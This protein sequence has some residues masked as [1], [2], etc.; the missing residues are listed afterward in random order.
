MS[1]ARRRHPTAPRDACELASRLESIAGQAAALTV[2][3]ET[4]A[5]LDQATLLAALDA[6]CDE[7]EGRP[8]EMMPVLERL[9]AALAAA[10]DRAL[11]DRDRAPTRHRQGTIRRRPDPPAVPRAMVPFLVRDRLR[12]S[13]ENCLYLLARARYRAL[14]GRDDRCDCAARIAAVF[15]FHRPD[16][17]LEL[18]DSAG[19]PL[20]R[21]RACGTSWREEDG[22]DHLHGWSPVSS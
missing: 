8:A 3:D 11:D 5:A 21:C 13:R 20:W 17:P 18:V 1:S 4:A 6:A 15:L 16:A 2:G 7:A 22:H 12:A 10:L 14:R 9:E 19:V